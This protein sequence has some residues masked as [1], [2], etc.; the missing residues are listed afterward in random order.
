LAHELAHVVQ[1]SRGEAR[2]QRDGPAAGAP[3]PEPAHPN[4]TVL[5]PPPAVKQT[6][7]TMTCW[8]A[9]LS[10]WLGAKNIPVSTNDI[11]LRY[12]TTSCVDEDNA[13]LLATAE[14]VYAEWGAKFTL[15]NDTTTLTGAVVRDLLSKQGHLMIAQLGHP[16]GHVIVV[17]GSGF[18]QT[19]KPNPDYISVMDPWTGTYYNTRLARLDF[20]VEVGVPGPQV[21]DAACL[22]KKTETPP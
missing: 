10:S 17:Y 13:L 16:T 20:P 9:A 21:R 15:Y 8:A 2:I 22:K 3:A 18:D 1:Q 7:S 14:D 5:A 11:L 19:G 4:W 6:H 12:T